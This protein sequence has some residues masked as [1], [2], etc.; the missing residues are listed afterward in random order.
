MTAKQAAILGS[1][2][3][4]TQSA[5]T[6]RSYRIT[7]SLPYA[8]HQPWPNGFPSTHAPTHWP[9]VYLL[10]ACWFC[11]MVTDMARTMAFC[12]D[13]TDAI[14]VGIGYPTDG[15]M[16]ETFLDAIARRGNDF[17]PVRDEAEDEE[18]SKTLMRPASSGDAEGFYQFLRN[19]LI[20]L[21]E[22]DYRAD[23]TKRIL[24]GHS[25]GGLFGAFALLREPEL[26]DTYIL[27]SPA[28]WV[29]NRWVFKQEEGYAQGHQ[30]LKA[31]VY[32]SAGEREDRI[33]A[34]M[35]D[36]AAVLGTRNY[37]GLTLVKQYFANMNHCEVAAPAFHAGLFWALRK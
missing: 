19:E 32:L 2:V 31:R 24:V 14:V 15:D 4:T 23:P 36:F 26:F 21:I 22:N 20:P 34:G 25:A 18:L 17:W 16:Q 27:A 11:G 8:Y 5:Q 9:V 35:F 37:E 7:I 28:F 10:D 30:R 1:E 12:G 29:G 33:L 13:T 3:R 6:G